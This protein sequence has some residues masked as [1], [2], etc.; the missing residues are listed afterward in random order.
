MAQG[1]QLGTFA[2]FITVNASINSVS[3]GTSFFVNSASVSV[4]AAFT[5]SNLISNTVSITSALSVG[6]STVNTAITGS[7]IEGN[8]NDTVSTP[9][10][11]WS[12]DTTTG[13]YRPGANQVGI[14]VGGVAEIICNT[15]VVTV[16]NDLTVVPNTFNLGVV[17]KAA[18]GYTWLPNGLLMQWGTFV[19]N[20]I[21]QPVFPVSFPNAVVSIQAIG[22]TTIHRGANTIT[23]GTVNLGNAQI[24]SAS[25][26]TT[27]NAYYLAIG[28]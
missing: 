4:N 9:S 19:C 27:A 7:R 11:T 1:F 6:N 24:L 20:T 26:T 12:T 15:S 5:A 25:T 18:N 23:I 13:L 10:F 22:R 17:S 21:S 8:Q 2:N 14:A 28:Y 3:F 16:N